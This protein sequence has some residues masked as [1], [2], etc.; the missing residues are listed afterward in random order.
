MMAKMSNSGC[1]TDPDHTAAPAGVPPDLAASWRPAD[2][3]GFLQGA[4]TRLR[5]ACWNTPGTPR[6]SIVVLQGR[7]E[8][9][10]KYGTEVV[11]EL[12]DRGF[13][14]FAVD[15]RGQGLSDRPLADHDKGHVDDFATYVADLRLFLDKIIAP[16][17]PRPILA[18]SHSTSGNILLRSLA[19]QGAGPLSAAAFVSPMTGLCRAFLIRTLLAVTSP[20]GRRDEA[21]MLATGPYDPRH[22]NFATNDV[23]ADERR[24]RFTDQWFKSDPRLSLGGPTI[25]WLR[26]GLRSIDRL[27]SPGVL[28]RIDLPVLVVSAGDDHVVDP[29]S[30]GPAVARMRDAQHVVVDGARHEI[31]M[32]TDARRAQFW[33]A[34]DRLAARV[35]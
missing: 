8:F 13:T 3:Y 11:P 27:V 17:A 31:L 34:F 5:Y 10:E 30:H 16:T 24:Y 32:E 33:A 18:L 22:R 20:F 12:L 4:G 7:A 9:I 26:Q 15:L 2:R 6:G 23:T 28:E 14:V 19:E 21:Y 25:G 1:M 29:T 35:A